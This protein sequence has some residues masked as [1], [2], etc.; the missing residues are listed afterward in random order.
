M[1]FHA[2]LWNFEEWP[3]FFSAW[4]LKEELP[5]NTEAVSTQSPWLDREGQKVSDFGLLAF[6]TI[7]VVHK[8]GRSSH[9]DEAKA[10]SRDMRSQA[11]LLASPQLCWLVGQAAY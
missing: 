3:P 6:F 4:K 1:A 7:G 8:N 2:L 11:L 9:V 5:A 10:L